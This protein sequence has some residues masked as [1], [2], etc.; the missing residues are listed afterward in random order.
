MSTISDIYSTNT[1]GITTSTAITGKSAEQMD[2]NDFFTLLT[3]QMT[4]Q[5]MMDPQ[6]NTEFIAQMAQFSS[7]QGIKTLT[8]YQQAGNA[9]TYV[10]QEVTIA[11]INESTGNVESIK[12]IVEKVTFYDGKPQVVVNGKAYDVYK[13]ME[14]SVP[15]SSGSTLNQVASYIGKNVTVID[16]TD[17][18]NP[19]D[20]TGLVSSVTLKGGV[21]YVIIDGKE[22]ASSSIT[23]V[24]DAPPQNNVEV[25]T[26]TEKETETETEVE[27]ETGK[28]LDTDDDESGNEETPDE[29]P[30]E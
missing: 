30:P 14:T 26:G 24:G 12:G 4:N 6:G 18:D 25:G 3:A 17:P 21:P 20:L 13:V 8:E 16:A 10:G 22:Y 15:N 19:K 7:L 29:M 28:V 11:N 2:M 23:F 5:D 9:L 27:T 1:G